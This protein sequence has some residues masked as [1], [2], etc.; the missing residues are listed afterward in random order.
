MFRY[1]LLIVLFFSTK[2]IFCGELDD[3]MDAYSR[4]EQS[5]VRSEK[6]ELYNKALKI[7]LANAKKDPS[8]ELLYNIGTTY[9]QLGDYGMAIAFFRRAELLIPLDRALKLNLEHAIS[10]ANV[11]GHQIDYK[12]M[13]MIFLRWC[14]PFERGLL[15][16]GGLSLS[17][18]FFSLN[19]WL[20]SSGLRWVSR[21]TIGCTLLAFFLVVSYSFFIPSRGV[22]V[23]ATALRVMSSGSDESKFIIH[24]GEMVEILYISPDEGPVRIKTATG[25]S[26]FLPRDVVCVVE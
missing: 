14:S 17:F 20:P 16:L 18:I 3:A 2:C 12:L 6:E 7:F 10:L 1:F 19:L 11:R 24:S 21:F 9:M 22:V 25:V 26:G 15:L 23:K 13:N 5:T 4:A 8:G